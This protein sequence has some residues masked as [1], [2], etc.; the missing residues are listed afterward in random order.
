MASTTTATAP[1]TT[2][3]ASASACTAG[4]RRLRSTAM[5]I[6][7]CDPAAEARSS[8]I[9]RRRRTRTNETC[10]GIDNDCDGAHRQRASASATPAPPASAPANASRR[11]CN[12][13]D[14][15]CDGTTDE[16]IAPVRTECGTGACADTGERTCREGRLV[17]SCD[18]GEPGREV[19]NGTDDDCDGRTDEGIAPVARLW[20]RRLRRHGRS[21]PAAKAAS[22]T[23]A[24]PAT[25]APRS[26]MPPTM[27]ATAAPTNRGHRHLPR[28]HPN[29]RRRCLRRLQRRGATGGRELQ[30]RRSRLRRPHR[31]AGESGLLWRPRLARRASALCRGWHPS[32][33]GRCLRR[34]QWRGATERSRPATTPTTTATAAPTKASAARVIAARLAPLGVGTCR[35]GTQA[36][37][38]RCLRRL[39]RR[40]AA[41]R[42]D[43]RRAR[44]R[45]R[46][47]LR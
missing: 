1:S 27:T 29:L 32:L 37:R 4:R 33:R 9:R 41:G 2:S 36:L 18:A 42:R 3:P 17:D 20:H 11:V 30:Q 16:G 7:V 6:R 22:S 47:R 39:Q 44:Q 38:R 14:D 26:A 13:T 28:W 43:L 35:S 31:R 21:A 46:R 12:G 8:A 5:C 10:D 24:T 23:P 19:C 45:L 25:P 40:G 15:D 34:L